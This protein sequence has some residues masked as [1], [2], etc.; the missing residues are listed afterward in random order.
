MWGALPLVSRA[1]SRHIQAHQEQRRIPFAKCTGEMN[2]FKSTV[3]FPTIFLTVTHSECVVCSH[4]ARASVYLL[5]A[6]DSY[7]NCAISRVLCC[8]VLQPI[9]NISVANNVMTTSLR[10]CFL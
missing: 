6:H 10:I 5:I 8:D 4:Y 9:Q 1:S 3:T 7:T 2:Q